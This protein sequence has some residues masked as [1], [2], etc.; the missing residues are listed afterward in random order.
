LTTKILAPVDAL[1]NLARFIPMPGQRHDNVGV[2]FAVLL[3]GKAVDTDAIRADLNERGAAA[4]IPPESN[5]KHRF[6]ATWICTNGAIWSI[7]SYAKSMY[8]AVS[9]P[10][11][12]RLTRASGP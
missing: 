3:A 9:P 10:V 1:G 4:V 8:S 5:R 7:I 6:P 12:T 2:E 11:A